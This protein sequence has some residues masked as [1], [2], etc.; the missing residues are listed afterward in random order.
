VGARQE[1]RILWFSPERVLFA[2]VKKERAVGQV[3]GLCVKARRMVPVQC[4]EHER[5]IT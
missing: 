5:T 1:Q 2:A 4:T 3:Q